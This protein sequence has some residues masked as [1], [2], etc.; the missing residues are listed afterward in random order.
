MSRDGESGMSGVVPTA[1]GSS[2]L[3]IAA[4]DQIWRSLRD[5]VRPVRW[6]LALATW[7]LIAA[8]A[9]SLAGPAL[10]G[11]VV[12]AATAGR[13]RDLLPLTVAFAGVM[14]LGATFIWTGVVRLAAVGE[15]MLRTLRVSVYDSLLGLPLQTAETARTG[16]LLSRAT[17]DVSTLTAASRVVPAVMVALL[18]LVLTLVA[19]VLV[20]PLL[21][22]AAVVVVPF[23]AFGGRWYLRRAPRLYADLRAHTSDTIDTLHEAHDGI[24]TLLAFNRTSAVRERLQRHADHAYTTEMRA[25]AVRNVVRPTV[26]TGQALALGVALVVGTIAVGEG[27]LTVGVVTAAT[28]YLLRLSD[29]VLTLL[30]LLD[31]LQAAFAALGRIVGLVELSPSERDLPNPEVPAEGSASVRALHFG[32]D[33]GDEVLHD[34]HLDLAPG[35]RIVIV[36]PS[37]AGKTTLAKL[38]AGIHPVNRGTIL[39]G[40]V[41]LER[42]ERG[43][44]R[45][46]VQLVT[47][48]QHV[49]AGT[50]AEDLRLA[51]PEA[52]DERVRDALDIVGATP[53]INALPLGIQTRVGDGGR[54]LTPTQVQQVSLARLLL[55]DPPMVVLDEATAALDPAAAR[56]LEGALR[57]ALA[58]RTVLMVTHRL[59]AATTADRIVVM[60]AGRITAV[61][62]HAELLS[63]DG[64]YA[65][66]F[67]AWSATT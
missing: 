12:D 40:G 65:A 59:D 60:E 62:A 64:G 2:I 6:R 19:L 35:E 28:L 63:Q 4:A 17:A 16:D 5:L 48:E 49:F 47:Q 51:A 66:L 38:V 25:T 10:L 42:I 46:H 3:P 8:T 43:Q 53:W 32:Y 58:G 52:T 61:G 34:V 33:P 45:Q 55:A 20:A 26:A 23:V 18:E 50:V 44:L 57:R 13:T 41:P 30:E 67:R 24:R 29:P 31:E 11:E 56:S 9:L 39:L 37:G 14:A 27:A 1:A 36:G 21:A 22:L 54:R 7:L 15:D